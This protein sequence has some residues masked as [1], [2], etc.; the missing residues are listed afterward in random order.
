MAYKISIGFL[1]ALGSAVAFLLA[2]VMLWSYIEIIGFR[3]LP[4]Y[5]Q[6]QKISVGMPIQEAESLMSDYLSST[7][8]EVSREF[9][10]DARTS[11]ESPGLH[12]STRELDMR[13]VMS[14]DDDKVSNVEFYND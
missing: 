6:C 4:F 13:C 2:A 10:A 11:L 3:L 12:L 5:R 14:Y 1:I 9:H 8:V 7:F